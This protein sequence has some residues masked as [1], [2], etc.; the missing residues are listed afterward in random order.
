MCDGVLGVVVLD[1]GVLGVDDD[2]LVVGVLGVLL[3]LLLVVL[4]LSLAVGLL[5][6]VPVGLLLLGVSASPE[7]SAVV[8]VS[9]VCVS[10]VSVLSVS[11]CVVLVSGSNVVSFS[12]LQATRAKTR[13]NANSSA[14]IFFIFFSSIK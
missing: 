9:L 5:V 7:F 13:V 3:G 1:E 12:L 11:V 14:K 4:P 6:S 10:L 8:S 2:V